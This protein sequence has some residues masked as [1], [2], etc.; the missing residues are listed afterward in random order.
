MKS[1][2]AVDLPQNAY[3]VVIAPDALDH[4]GGWVA[5]HQIPLGPTGQ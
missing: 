2:I 1:V 3:E 4:V 5:E